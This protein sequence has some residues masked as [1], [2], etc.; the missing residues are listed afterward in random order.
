[1]AAVWLFGNRISRLRFAEDNKA[2]AKFVHR[3]RL[4]ATIL[5]VL[6]FSIGSLYRMHVL[7]KIVAIPLYIPVVLY[8]FWGL[9]WLQPYLHEVKEESEHDGS[10]LSK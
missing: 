6:A 7:S 8:F 5:S 3:F 9:R 10:K 2:G 4:G 1:M